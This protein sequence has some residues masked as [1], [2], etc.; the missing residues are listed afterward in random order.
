MPTA[1]ANSGQAEV[2]RA[3]TRGGIAFI[4]N[5][6]LTSILGVVYWLAAAHVMGQAELGRGSSLLSALLTVSALAQ[7]NYTRTLPGLL[8]KASNNATRLLVQVYMRVMI[9]SFILGLSF[10]IITP[11]VSSK[12]GYLTGIPAFALLFAISVPIYS[13]FSLEDSV[14]ATV[15]RTAIIPFE[16]AIYGVLKLV[17]L[18]IPAFLRTMPTGTVILAS[19]VLPLLF[20]VIPINIYLFRRAVPQAAYAFPDD[21]ASE[22]GKLVRYDFAGYLFWLLGTVPLPVLAVTFLGPYRTAAF[23]VPFT[24]VTAIDVLSLNLGNQLTAEMSRTRGEFRAPTKLFVWRAWGVIALISAGLIV[25]APYVL[26]LFGAQYRSAGTTVFRVL[27]LAALPRSILF[28]SIAT[29]RARG[30]AANAQLSGPVILALQATTCILTLAISLLTMPAHGILGIAFGWTIASFIGAFIAVIGVTP[31]VP[32]MVSK[33]DGKHRKMPQ[34]RT[35]L[36]RRTRQTQVRGKRLNW[37]RGSHFADPETRPWYPDDRR[38]EPEIVTPL[39]EPPTLQWHLPLARQDD[40]MLRHES[41]DESGLSR[42]EEGVSPW[43][44]LEMRRPR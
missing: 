1:N 36:Q 10:A 14:L 6:A 39:G 13:I 27:M 9:V 29:A 28:F 16:N 32:R 3:L 35:G 4:S 11:L 17:P 43:K 30:V 22:E 33:G 18:F 40:R 20:L 5:S 7:L 42:Y 21:V 44:T 31:P 8:P 34:A 38:N 2:H 37:G 24:I 41:Y 23:S 26:D 15:R 12:F 19:W 25:M